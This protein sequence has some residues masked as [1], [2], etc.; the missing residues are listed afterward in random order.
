MSGNFQFGTRGIVDRHR[1]R[2]AIPVYL[3]GPVGGLGGLQVTPNAQGALKGLG[4]KWIQ[5]LPLPT[6]SWVAYIYA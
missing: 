3:W 1:G 4:G 5:R 6:V 2:A